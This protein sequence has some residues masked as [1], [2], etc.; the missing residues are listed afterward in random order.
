[1]KRLDLNQPATDARIIGFLAMREPNHAF[2]T[3]DIPVYESVADPEADTV[4]LTGAEADRITDAAL[5]G[6]L[7][8]ALSKGRQ[9]L[10]NILQSDYA[11]PRHPHPED[12]DEDVAAMD[13]ALRKARACGHG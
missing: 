7:V 2:P 6:E 1:M 4:A 10:A 9:A 12:H 3:Y 8:A 11:T 5:I 13:A